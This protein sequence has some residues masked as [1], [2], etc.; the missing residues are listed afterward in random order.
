[1][2]GDLNLEYAL[3]GLPNH[4]S[5]ENIA[6]IN[7]RQPKTKEQRCLASYST[8]GKHDRWEEGENACHIVLDVRPRLEL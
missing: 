8:R 4:R 6:S 5:S 3:S 2:E 7:S 1:M